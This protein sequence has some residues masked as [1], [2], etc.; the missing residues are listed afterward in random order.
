MRAEISLH[1]GGS[2]V[3]AR[4]PKSVAVLRAEDVAA[5]KHD[6][7][8]QRTQAVLVI[9]KNGVVVPIAAPVRDV[10]A[11]IFGLNVPAREVDE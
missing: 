7:D 5:I 10:A 2:I 1:A 6:H 11:A 9:L 3:L 4:S 8:V